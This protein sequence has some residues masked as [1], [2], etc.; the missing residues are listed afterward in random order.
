LTWWHAWFYFL[1]LWLI[2][3][4]TVLTAIFRIRN[5]SE[6]YGVGSTHELNESRN[7][8]PA[9]WERMLIAPCNVNFH[10]DHHLF[11]SVPWYNLPRLHRV[12]MQQKPYAAHAHITHTYCGL[13]RGLLAE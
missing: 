2:P 4:F 6:H 9:W 11:P 7:V 5:L 1:V 3:E 10:L 8:L 13:H 12:L